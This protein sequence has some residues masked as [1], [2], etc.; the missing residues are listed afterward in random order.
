MEH[1]PAATTGE[2]YDHS[3]D[4]GMGGGPKMD[5]IGSREQDF[6]T[7]YKYLDETFPT[8]TTTKT[9]K[10]KTKTTKLRWGL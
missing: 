1:A 4:L 9:T 10:T 3:N 6:V 2:V 7:L 5:G 8:T